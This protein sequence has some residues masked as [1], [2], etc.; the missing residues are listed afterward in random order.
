MS[1]ETSKTNELHKFDLNLSQ[2]LD[3]GSSNVCFTWKNIRKP[4][5][6]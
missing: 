2:I 5:K 1:M 3:L 6:Q 4:Y